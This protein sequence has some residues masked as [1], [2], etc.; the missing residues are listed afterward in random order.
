MISKNNTTDLKLQRDS[1]F[2]L[3]EGGNFQKKLIL[4]NDQPLKYSALITEANLDLTVETSKSGSAL[5]LFLLTPV[6][7]GKPSKINVDL[8]LLHDRCHLDLTIVSLV[9]ADE[10]AEASA[11]IYMQPNIK[12]S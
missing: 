11:T 10:K 2:E 6:I 9:F 12:E 3:R 7:A 8:R 1:I 5:Q 4:E